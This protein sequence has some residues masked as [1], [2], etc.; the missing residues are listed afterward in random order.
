MKKHLLRI[1]MLAA[2]AAGVS[3]A[4]SAQLTAD[5]PFPFVL[6]N[7]MLP[8]GTYQVD[9]SAGSPAVILHAADGQNASVIA[10]PTTSA[11]DQKISKLVFQRYGDRYF[12][13][14]IWTRGT[15]SGRQ[16]PRTSLER[17]LS[18]GKSMPRTKVMVAAR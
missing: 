10:N 6:G 1:S 14:E 9:E 16:I 4:Q 12:L 18:A 15:S 11:R 17:E 8:A 3:Q 2:L 7:K 5:V 13:A